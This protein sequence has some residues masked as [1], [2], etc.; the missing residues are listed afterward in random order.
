M[1]HHGSAV[2]MNIRITM[3]QTLASLED[4]A[5]L[6]S[7]CSFGSYED[8]I[9]DSNAMNIF[10][11]PAT[12]FFATDMDSGEILGAARVLS[13]DII[14]SYLAEICVL[15]C[16]RGTGLAE[17]LLEAVATRFNHTAIFTCGFI[18]MERFLKSQGL[19]K[20]DKLFACSRKPH[21]NKNNNLH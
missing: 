13:D 5:K 10:R 18:G 14:T 7:V 19:S 17:K 21:F 3:D 1:A 12:G 11:A 20:K 8:L 16:Y 2:N 6:Y 15:P 4:I 9:K